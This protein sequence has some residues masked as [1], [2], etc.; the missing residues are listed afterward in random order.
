MK[1]IWLILSFATLMV[2][3]SMLDFMTLKKAEEAYHDNNYTKAIKSYESMKDKNDEA[4]YNLANAYYKAKKYKEAKRLYESLKLPTLAHQ[5]WHNIGN[6]DANLGDI[7]AGIK[8]YEKALKLKQDEE[9]KYNLELL[10]KKKKEKEQQK[11]KKNDKKKNDKKNKDK[12]KN[13]KKS[14][15]EKNN[16]DKK[17]SKDKQNDKKKS[18]KQNDKKKKSQDKKSKGNDDKKKKPSK[19]KK[20]NPSKDKKEKEQEK[21]KQMQEQMKKAKEAKDKEKKDKAQAMKAFKKE[22]I[23]DKEVS[24]YLKMLD[25]RGVNT[26]LVPLNTKGAKD[27]ETTP[28]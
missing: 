12:K 11:K 7:D 23:S 21:A 20:E 6:C 8:A 16:Q 27:E 14:D 15:K 19:P 10:K 24:K 18:D 28:W 3:A 5:K 22:P 2:H 4:R 13:N 26:L 25:K 17:G 1:K 9:T